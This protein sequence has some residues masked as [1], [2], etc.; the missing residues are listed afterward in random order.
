M[1]IVPRMDLGI[2]GLASGFDWRSLVDQLAE[3][4]RAPQKRLRTEQNLIEQRNNAY[5]SILTQ[6]GVLQNRLAFLKD[7]SLLDTRQTS[8][9]DDTVA[10]VTAEAGA[11]LGNYTFNFLQLASAAKQQG[12]S[13]I[14]RPLN[15]T[16]DV[17]GLVLS[18]AG[19]VTSLTDGSFTVNGKQITVATNDTLQQVFDKIGAATGGTVSG[20]YD[21]STDKISLSSSGEIV[22][23]SATDTSNFLAVTKLNNNGTGAIVSASALGGVKQAVVLSGANLTTAISDGG[24]GAGEFKI[25]GVSISFDAATDS[26]QKV[27]DRINGST[28]GVTAKYDA[29]NDRLAL[30]NNSTGDIGI[31]LEDVTGN[32]LAATALSSGTLAHGKDLIYAIDG[33]DPLISRSNT[34]TEAT[35]GITGLSVTAL[36]EG[37]STTVAIASDTGKIKTAITAFVAEYNKAQSLIDSQTASSTDA[38]GKVTAGVLAGESAAEEIARKVRGIANTVLSNLPGPIKS[39]SDLGIES[40]GDDNTLKISDGSKLDAALSNNLASVKQLFADS[41]DGL[42]VQLDTYLE[43]TSGTDGTLVNK[44]DNLTKSAS[45]IDTQ[46]ADLERIVQADRQRLIDSFIAMERAKRKPINSCN[47]SSSGSEAPPNESKLA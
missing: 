9:G 34:V 24:H 45:D 5:G 36:K 46:V 27:I 1:P 40:N 21:A 10:S 12:S 32:F 19:L 33:G 23:G 3:V 26:L 31:G 47:S 20:S 43:K 16:N 30:T 18:S 29:I 39:L 15:A 35:S 8:V 25:N 7:P 38:K 6:F 4:E 28:A 11:V 44:Q 41:T 22:L 2:S 17:S 14:G 42:A 37:V 13:D